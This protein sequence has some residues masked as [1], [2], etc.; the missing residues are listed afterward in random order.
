MGHHALLGL[1]HELLIV[2]VIF[3]H[4]GQRGN[5]PPAL[6]LVREVLEGVPVIPRGFLGLIRAHGVIGAEM[7]EVAAVLAGVGEHAVQHDAD[8]AFLGLFAQSLELLL[9][10]HQRINLHIIA[11]IIAVIAPGSEDG[12]QVQH[13]HA[14]LF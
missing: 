12:V 14:Q 9:R 10:A 11:G 3:A 4:L 8:A 6:V 2:R 13:G 1:E 5:I 7:V